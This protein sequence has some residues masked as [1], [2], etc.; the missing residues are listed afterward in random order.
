[1]KKL[2]ALL[3]AVF[4]LCPCES[5]LAAKGHFIRHAKRDKA[6]D[7]LIYY[8]V[9]E[10]PEMAAGMPMVVYLHGSSERGEGALESSLP[11]FVRSKEVICDRT[12]L[13]VPQLPE[14]IT[15]WNAVLFTLMNIIDEVAAEYEVDEA[16]IALTGFSLGGVGVWDLAGCFPGRFTRV[17]SVSGRVNAD[18][19][20]DAFEG[21][22][23]KTCVG[24]EDETVSPASAIAFTQAL[25]DAGFD[26]ELIQLKSSHNLMPNKIYKNKEILEWLWLEKAEPVE[27]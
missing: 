16:R 5:A 9:Y 22:E 7:Q 15:Q 17:L 11:F 8:W 23:I 19:Y 25:I 27:E 18:I 26:A 21:C 2:I 1:M 6:T 14:I 20:I 12:L 4:L 3:L 10:P 13:L 24:T